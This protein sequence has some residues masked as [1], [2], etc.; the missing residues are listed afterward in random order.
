MLRVSARIEFPFHLLPADCRPILT[1]TPK[2]LL[3]ASKQYAHE[4]R[5]RSWW[6]LGSTFVI[7]VTLLAVAFFDFPWLARCS[8]GVLA[9]L[10][11]VRLFVL[12]HDY[13]HHAI[14]RGSP[15]AAVFMRCFGVFS[16][17][18]PSYWSYSHGHHHTH[19]ARSFGVAI[20]T[21]EEMTTADFAQASRCERLLYV[22][23]RHPLTIALAYLSVFLYSM[24]LRSW[25]LSPRKHADAG[26]AL[27]VH[28]GLVAGLAYYD[29]AT[30][31]VTITLPFLIAT[32]VGSYLFYAQHNY[33]AVKLRD[34]H[35]WSYVHAALH[36]SSYLRMGGLMRWF[37]GNIGYHHVHHLNARIPFYRLPEAMAGLPELQS[38]GVTTLGLRDIH[39]CLRLKLWDREQDRLVT[40]REG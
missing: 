13:L 16:L 11:H 10:V 30:L 28:V 31:L 12:Y 19:N 7:Y 3:I 39:A 15:A 40:W 14:L 26:I 22:L 36:S 33:P 34:S 21:F 20:G 6:H 32:A 8:A 23:T 9:G 1:R 4:N 18:P 24:C 29:V 37:T 17:A 2:E 27:L 35:E 5:A 25:L 38:P